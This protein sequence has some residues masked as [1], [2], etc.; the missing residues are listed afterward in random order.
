MYWEGKEKPV[1]QEA[2]DWVPPYHRSS[3]SNIERTSYA[4]MAMIGDG[5]D[6]NALAMARPIVRWLSKQR[7]ALGGF[8]ST[9]VISHARQDYQY[10]VELHRGL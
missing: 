2:G 6:S 7:N 4:L 5:T 9:Q 1:K 8:A 3:S 10:L